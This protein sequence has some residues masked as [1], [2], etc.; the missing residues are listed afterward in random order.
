[1]RTTPGREAIYRKLDSIRLKEVSFPGLPLEEVVGKLAT[2]IAASDPD[3]KGIN[4]IIDHGMDVSGRVDPSTGLPESQPFIATKIVVR[5]M[6]PLRDVTARQA[7]DAIVRVA[8]APFR[9]SVEEYAVVFTPR[10]PPPALHTRW[11]R[12]DPNIFGRSVSEWATTNVDQAIKEAISAPPVL[13]DSPLP[14][15][16]NRSSVTP[17][18]QY[19]HG[20]ARRFFA[21]AGVDF[22][23]PGKSLV[24]NERLGQL[25]VR[26]T[27][28]DLD[29]IEQAILVVNTPPPQVTIEVKFAE[30][31]E[32]D[33]KALGFDWFLRNTLTQNSGLGPQNR[34]ATAATKVGEPAPA[35]AD[36]LLNLFQELRDHPLPALPS[37]I[38][39]NAPE[40][41][42]LT[43]ILTDAQY[44]VVLRALEQRQGVNIL[45]PPKVT[46]LSGRQ[47][48]VKTVT[49]RYVVTDLDFSQIVSNATAEAT[50]A[51]P[52]PVA[53]QF[54]LGPVLDVVPY[55][56]ADGRT[57]QMT[58]IP[59]LR[60]FLGYDVEN[61]RLVPPEAKSA[62]MQQL[63]PLPIFRLRQIVSSV[64]VSDGQT[65]VLTGGSDQ[66]L[67]NPNK[68]QPLREGTKPPQE[69][70]KTKL[71]VFV[72]ATLIDPAG[73]RLHPPE[74]IAPRVPARETAPPSR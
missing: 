1:V 3:R 12:I 18:D 74:E 73:N 6:P 50:S 64:T 21:K 10:P 11:F 53:E 35:V 9:Y 55:V 56:Q 32:P 14:G 59:T 2:L 63:T 16:V 30:I 26:A 54:E 38:G 61:A 27:L 46:T 39:A 67:A 17:T 33:S 42:P 23:V 62:D 7:I 65:V 41:E 66:L 44:R 37:S 36:N 43:G 71:L 57:I 49:V 45:T 25:V 28:E 8:E 4:F 34:L 29:I 31:T 40:N 58:V 22:T 60:E 13:V 24:F 70:K 52:K 5:L 51:Q 15:R 47:A 72:T 19:V 48:Q 69:P 68:N 20:E